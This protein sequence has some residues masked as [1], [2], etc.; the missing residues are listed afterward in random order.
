[1]EKPHVA[2]HRTKGPALRSPAVIPRI[3]HHV[4]VGPDPLPQEFAAYRESWRRHH[5][6]WEM[7]LWTEESLPG[8]L[9]RPEVYERLRNPA[10]RSDILRLEVLFRFG[11]LY[12][13][14]DVECLR[15]IDPLL[16]EGVDFFVN[17]AGAGRAHN[18][19][20]GAVA[21]HP[22][23]EQALRELQ[24]V[25][26]F[27][28]DK[29]G[30]GPHFL[31]ALLRQHPGVMICPPELFPGTGGQLD[32]AYAQHHS[33]ATWKTPELWKARAQRSQEKLVEARAWNEELESLIGLRGPGAAIRA[34]RSRFRFGERLRRA[35]QALT[36]GGS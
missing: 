18:A 25:T 16:E 5:P 13:D 23:L 6:E 27:G 34:W 4:W 20:I 14:T 2:V 29:H 30:T 35:W 15:P 33:A 9:V 12:V 36:P 17:S 24:P 21:G 3:L 22:V 11:G 32:Q 8:D 1:M 7:R 10:E 19:V 31:G 26:E 28:V